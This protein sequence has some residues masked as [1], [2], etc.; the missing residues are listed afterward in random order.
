MKK[1]KN[2]GTM[3][4]FAI[5]TLGI[6]G[7]AAAQ[8]QSW[9]KKIK[10]GKARLKLLAPFDKEAVLDR[11]TGLVWE[12]QPPTTTGDWDTAMD[13]CQALNLGGRMGW[14]VPTIEELTS[15]VDRTQTSPPL[16]FK[17]PFVDVQSGW[18]WTSTTEPL[19][20]GGSNRKR[21]Y[22]FGGSG[23]FSDAATT[24]AGGYTWCVRGG[25]TPDSR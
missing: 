11:E 23:T 21:M 2:I 6:A 18:Y 12:T 17:H 13:R 3:A 5:L 1:I 25:Q 9:F 20:A 22:Y 8:S 10:N 24:W 4:L 15:L 19:N 7:P 14:R 16:P